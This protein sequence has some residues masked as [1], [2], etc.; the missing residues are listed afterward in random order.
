[1]RTRVYRN[2]TF[3]SFTTESEEF[4]FR[5]DNFFTVESNITALL[6]QRMEDG[7]EPSSFTIFQ[8]SKNGTMRRPIERIYTRTN[9]DTIYID[10]VMELN[11]SNFS[12]E[13]TEE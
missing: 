10:M 11:E 2:F 3:K 6:K 7:E 8:E 9:D 12:E 5:S 1:M 4:C 13:T